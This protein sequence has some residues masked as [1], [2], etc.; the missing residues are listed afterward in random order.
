MK[1]LVNLFSGCNIH[2][3]IHFFH[4]VILSSSFICAYSL[5]NPGGGGGGGGQGVRTPP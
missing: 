4:C 5:A 1:P 2:F 3:I